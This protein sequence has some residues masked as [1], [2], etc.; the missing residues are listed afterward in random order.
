MMS[1]SRSGAASH[2]AVPAKLMT[3]RLFLVLMITVALLAG[4]P[5]IASAEN[6]GPECATTVSL[7][8]ESDCCG[9]S[10][11]LNCSM[12]CTLSAC[13]AVGAPSDF[14]IV[15]PDVFSLEHAVAQRRLFVRPPD[16][17]PPKSYSALPVA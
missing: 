6:A 11:S 13:A 1:P 10:E 4:A 2:H 8:G 7:G 5:A 15:V 3:L 9:G 14:L 12:V 17:T 16:T